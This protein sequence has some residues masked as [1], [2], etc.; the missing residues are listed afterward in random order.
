MVHAY[1]ITIGVMENQTAQINQMKQTACIYAN[2]LVNILDYHIVKLNVSHQLVDVHHSTSNAK[3]VDA[4]YQAC[5]VTSTQTALMVQM[6]GIA[7]L[8]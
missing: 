1:G 2:I 7:D 8:L 5:C 3:K 4:F 6:K